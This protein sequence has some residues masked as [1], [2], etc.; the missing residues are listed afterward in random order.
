MWRKPVWNIFEGQ[1]EIL[2][3]NAQHIKA[4]PGGRPTRRTASGLPP[5]AAW[6][7]EGQLCVADACTRTARFDA[8][9]CGMQPHRNRVQKVLED[10][11][12]KLASVAT[13]ALGAW[14]TL[15]V[16]APFRV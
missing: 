9:S 7:A 2:L 5:A 13:D 16:C 3:V 12:I 14:R 4:V 1:F 15:V 8:V 6:F 11:N 10:A